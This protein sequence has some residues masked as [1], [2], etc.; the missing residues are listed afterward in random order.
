LKNK[1]KVEEAI[2][3]FRTLVASVKQTNKTTYSNFAKKVSFQG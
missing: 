1:T 2:Q 3:T